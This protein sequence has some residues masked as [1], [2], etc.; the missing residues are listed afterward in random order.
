MSYRVQLPTAGCTGH[1]P[2]S[3]AQGWGGLGEA[4]ASKIPAAF[5]VETRLP[6]CADSG[7]DQAAAPNLSYVLKGCLAPDGAGAR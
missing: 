2:P 1:I 3:E 4:Q 7:L 6:P 5:A